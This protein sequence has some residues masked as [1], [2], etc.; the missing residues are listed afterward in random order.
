MREAN[1]ELSGKTPAFVSWIQLIGLVLIIASRV[2]FTESRWL[3][4]LGV[5]LA[6]AGY[7]VRMVFD[8]RQGNRK[9][10]WRRL[11]FLLIAFII[12]LFAGYFAEKSQ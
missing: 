6:F 11:I 1:S 7:V 2:Y 12:G 10:F 9:A 5:F 8:W 3:L 4:Y